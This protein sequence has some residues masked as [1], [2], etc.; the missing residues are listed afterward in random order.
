MDVRCDQ[1]NE[2]VRIVFVPSRSCIGNQLGKRPLEEKSGRYTKT[3]HPRSV[4]RGFVP[5]GFRNRPAFAGHLRGKAQRKTSA[6]RV[7]TL[8]RAKNG[9]ECKSFLLLMDVLTLDTKSSANCSH[10]SGHWVAELAN[11]LLIYLRGIFL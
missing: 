1:S 11:G 8:T 4:S 7:N 6:Q 3:C 10:W 5:C 9:N 2:P